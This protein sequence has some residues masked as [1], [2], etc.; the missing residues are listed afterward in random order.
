V[1]EL[2]TANAL[3]L[4]KYSCSGRV[5]ALPTGAINAQRVRAGGQRPHQIARSGGRAALLE[6]RQAAAR[7]CQGGSHQYWLTLNRRSRECA[8]RPTGIHACAA[9]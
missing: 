1:V 2:K 3:A 8:P 7:A 6:R 5:A 9:P 4:L